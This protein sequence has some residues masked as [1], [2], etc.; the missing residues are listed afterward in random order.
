MARARAYDAA[1]GRLLNF[2]VFNPEYQI[3][4]HF[5]RPAS[6]G[7]RPAASSGRVRG[8]LLI[9]RCRE[10]GG[11]ERNR[12]GEPSCEEGAR[13][14][15]RTERTRAPCALGA[16]LRYAS[17]RASRNITRAAYSAGL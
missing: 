15:R 4:G 11:D 10:N 13:T 16:T 5:S 1:E 2:N 17:E 3:F 9:R 14:A 6:V 8:I 7:R 12:E